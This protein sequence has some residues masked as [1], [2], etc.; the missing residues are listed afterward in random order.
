MTADTIL[1]QDQRDTLHRLADAIRQKQ[2]AVAFT[3][4]GISTESGIPDYRGPNGI[5]NKTQPTMYRD[6]ITDPAIRLR[7]WERRKNRYPVLAAAE[8]NSG[9]IALRRLQSA[10]YLQQIIT[11]NI[12]GLHQ[13]AGS[14][15]STILELHGSAHHIRC[16]DCGRVFPSEPFDRDYDGTEPTC[17]VCG[18]MVKE[19]TI[20]FGEPLVEGD[21]QRALTIARG[22]EVLVVVGSSLTVNP[23]AQVPREAARAGAGIAIINNQPTSLDRQAD[24]IINSAA[25]AALSYLAEELEV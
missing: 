24:F 5:W 1:T 22:A 9:H 12:D 6:F 23:A 11:Q 3:G 4:A 18:G 2:P 15:P 13:K 17:P 14:D 16:V 7:Y 21:L 19:A 10:G 8:P 25:G 20:S